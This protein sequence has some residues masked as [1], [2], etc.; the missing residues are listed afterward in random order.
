MKKNFL[1]GLAIGLLMT[2]LIGFLSGQAYALSYGEQL[3]FEWLYPDTSTVTESQV[4][5]VS[6]GVEFSYFSYFDIDVDPDTPDIYFSFN[7]SAG[8]ADALFNGFLFNDIYGA[9]D[10]FMDVSLYAT[11]LPGFTESLITFDDDNIWIN[12]EG[13]DFAPGD[14]VA[15]DISSAPIPE[16]ATMLL[17]GSGLV[18][19]AGFRRKYKK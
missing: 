5:T 13:L 7:D 9:V 1:S 16:P 8:F 14:Y 15:I 6:T 18:G 19:L 3:L 4:I 10:D 2:G 17:L 12:F 11:N